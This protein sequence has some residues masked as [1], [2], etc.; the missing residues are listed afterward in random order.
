MIQRKYTK[1]PGFRSLLCRGI[2]L[3]YVGCIKVQ[4]VQTIINGQYL[5]VIS[6]PGMIVNY[7]PHTIIIPVAASGWNQGFI[8]RIFFQGKYLVLIDKWSGYIIIGCGK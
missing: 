5:A 3:Q 6:I 8:G 4:F 2:K 1:E 7:P